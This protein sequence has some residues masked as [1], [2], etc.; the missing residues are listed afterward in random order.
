MSYFSDNYSKIKYPVSI[1]MENGLRN[2]QIG[3]IHAIASHFT[4]YEKQPGLIVMPTGSGKTAVLIMS[5]FIAQAKRVLV[6]SSS[7]LVRG[8]IF[9][10]FQSLQT[11]KMASVVE[12]NIR[13]PKVLEVNSPIRTIDEWNS[14]KNYDVVLGIPNSLSSGF[15]EELSPPVD[16]FDLILV[17][18]A[19]HSAAITW[20]KLI[21]GFADSKKVFFTATPFR[22]DKK[23]V[24][25]KI[26]YNYPLSKARK[27]RIFGEI[28]FY[29]ISPT[30]GESNDVALAKAA[31]K[32]LFEDRKNGLNHYILVRTN[33]KIHGQ[34]LEEIYKKYTKINLRRV[35][36][37]KTYKYIKTTIKKLK[38][39]ELDGIICVDMLGEG[40]DFPNLKIGVIHAPHKSLAVT[41]QFIGRFARTNAADIGAAKFLAIP[42][43][44]AI[45]RLHL[46]SQDAIWSDLIVDLN[47]GRILEEDAVKTVIETFTMDVKEPEEK[48]ELSI[49]NLNP[50]CHVKIYR[51]TEFNIEGTIKITGHEVIH[52]FQSEENS[53]VIIITQDAHRPKWII[54]D[55]LLD[56]N[57]YLFIAFYDNISGLLF[58]HSPFKTF[59]NYREFASAFAHDEKPIQISKHDINKVLSGLKETEIFNLG[60]Q[61]RSGNRGETYRTIAGPDASK[62]VK[63]SDGRMYSNGHIFGK[64]INEQEQ[65][66][67]IGYSSGSKVWSNAYEKIPNFINWCKNIGKKI[68]SNV[69]F[70]TNSGLDNLPIGLQIDRFPS[71]VFAASWDKEIYTTYPSLSLKNEA[72]ELLDTLPLLD[73]EITIIQAETTDLILHF[74]LVKGE[75]TFHL[76][77][78]FESH[79]Q[80]LYPLTISIFIEE[81]S[82]I[83]YLNEYPMQFYLVDSSTVI[84]GELHEPRVGQ[85]HFDIEQITAFDW[86]A[87]NTDINIEFYNPN[88]PNQVL[89]Q[90]N[91]NKDSI[92]ETIEIKLL[93]GNY[94]VIIYDHGTREAADF[95]TFREE[96]AQIEI[97]L[98]HIKSSGGEEGGDRVND[99]YEVCGQAIK[100]LLWTSTK[101]NFIRKIN[102]RIDGN[103][104]KFKKGN[105]QT[106]LDFMSLDKPI[107]YLISIVQPGISKGDLSE[108]IS[109]VLAAADYF[110]ASNGNNEIFSVIASD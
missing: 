29:P 4:L 2:A 23:E 6:V 42:N 34:E 106:Y 20:K 28:V 54:S 109:L 73:F 71:T 110:I 36:S 21:K 64:A 15:T 44:I 66:I 74:E 3:A 48:Q 30:N 105:N 17:D 90:N 1:G 14:C 7:V 79:Y 91:E 49:Y 96:P 13:L 19:H 50:Y 53:T 62:M 104:Q 94:D 99:V 76:T 51:I 18:E 75:L 25:G 88:N 72:G 43:E 56:I 57:Y 80:I 24:D 16:L 8:Q 86:K 97:N 92:H 31:E 107:H 69:E 59:Q 83:D 11:L 45:D 68:N 93:Q 32:I 77:Y 9:E 5:A 81:M 38:S 95:I 85:I 26:I 78:S 46:Y 87:C 37:N 55:E 27:D 22:R 100:S 39:K 103:P 33:T 10:E 63:K 40:F 52:R 61:N 108:K 47:E 35:D 65:R 89:K 70:K 82:L 60:M 67:T 98:F 84:Y 101:E 12:E 41:L 58:I 102:E